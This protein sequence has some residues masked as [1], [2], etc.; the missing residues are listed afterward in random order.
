MKHFKITL[1]TLLISLSSF[2]LNA[3]FTQ[4]DITFFSSY[5]FIHDS[6]ICSSYVNY[7]YQL[8]INN[9]FVG[10]STILISYGGSNMNVFYNTTGA[11]PWNINIPPNSDII[12][13]IMI[14]NNGF[15]PLID[16]QFFYEKVIRSF[17]TDTLF[18]SP[19]QESETVTNPCSYNTIQGKIYVDNNNDCIYNSGDSIINSYS[20]SVNPTFNNNPFNAYNI[21]SSGTNGYTIDIQESYFTSVDV[22]INPLYQ[23]V[24]PNNGCA[25]SSY[26]FNSLPQTGADFILQCADLD[27]SVSGNSAGLIRP[28]VPFLYYPS[29]TNIGCDPESGVLNLILDPNVIYN[30]ANSSNPADIVSGDT[31]KWNYSNLTNVSNGAY[32]QSFI[33][34]VEL[35]PNASL[36]VGDVINFQIFTHTPVN[37]V[38]I[39]NN[40]INLSYTL[41]NSYDPNYKEVSPKG[42]GVPGYISLITTKLTYTI[43]FQ[44]TGNAA[45]INISVLDSLHTNV[46]PNTLRILN[47]S[48]TMNPVWAENSVIKFNFDNINLPDSTSDEI[49]SHGF[50]TFEIELNSNL[51]IGDQIKN[52]AYIYFDNNS[53]VITNT[54]LNT[55]EVESIE[56]LSG[57]NNMTVQVYPNPTNGVTNF[58]IKNLASGKNIFTLYDISGK[59]LISEQFSKNNFQIDASQFKKGLYIYKIYNSDSNQFVNGKFLIK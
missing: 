57:L 20:P 49:N 22:S 8:Q 1:I 40:T 3:Q 54:T 51:S 27:L 12:S 55:L 6:T 2:T 7:N 47:S 38:N 16:F 33:G 17:S 29:A 35:T 11:N 18:V 34:G 53:P 58:M 19:A 52:T 46:N 25:P 32:W 13:D 59:I 5:N 48:H 24:F 56:E 30:P 28:T 50:V 21:S 43:N 26:T 10:D 37:D 4:G 44:N 42:Y 15:L 23:F 9:S 31:L 41:V 14:D 45:A 36:N 39:N